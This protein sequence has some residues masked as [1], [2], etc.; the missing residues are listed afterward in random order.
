MSSDSTESVYKALILNNYISLIGC[1]IVGYD[2][3]LTFPREIDYIWRRRWT[4]VSAIFVLVRYPGLCWGLLGD[5]L[6]TSFIPGPL[7]TCNVLFLVSCWTFPVFI[8]AADLVMILRVYAMW[9]RSRIILSILLFFFVLQVIVSV[10]LPAIYNSSPVYFVATTVQILNV[11][12]CGGSFIPSVPVLLGVYNAIPRF[13]IS[14]VLLIL[15]VSRT[16]KQSVDMYKATKQWQLNQYVNLFVRDG[17]FYFIINTVYNV[18]VTVTATPAVST[19]PIVANILLVICSALLCCCMPR[20][21]ISVREL[22]D[23]DLRG[24]WQGIDTGFGAMSREKAYTSSTIAFAGAGQEESRTLQDDGGIQI[25]MV[26]ESA[27]HV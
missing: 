22:F 4:W 15:A 25:E 13:L 20:F 18:I 8:C 12:I 7:N 11:T 5:L 3:I 16:L 19:P 26:G 9:N 27:Q 24:R 1:A 10:V 23:H 21:I 6:G 2:Y 17:I 14:A